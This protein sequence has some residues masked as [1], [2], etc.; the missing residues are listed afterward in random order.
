MRTSRLLHALLLA[1]GVACLACGAGAASRQQSPSS[2]AAARG[3]SAG[4]PPPNGERVFVRV[5]GASAEQIAVI[6]AAGGAIERL[7][8]DGVP[9]PDWSA[10]YTVAPRGGASTQTIVQA[11]DPASGAVLRQQAL[12]G[13]YALAATDLDGT[14]GGLSPSGRWLALTATSHGDYAARSS[15]LAVVDT[16]FMTPPKLVA[17]DGSFEFD[18]LSDD[19]ASL[20]LTERTR[21]DVNG[22]LDYRVRRFDLNAGALDPT[23]VVEKGGPEQMRG[24]RL[25]A[26]AAPNGDRLYSLYTN[27]P[28]GAFVHAL[29]LSGR[30]AVCIDLPNPPGR[31]AAAGSPAQEDL[32]LAWS[33][34]LSPGGSLLYAVNS[35]SGQVV[36]ID[37]NSNTVRRSVMLGAQPPR[38]RGPL[39]ALLQWLAPAPAAA[40]QLMHGGAALSADGGTLFV[41]TGNGV[42]AIDTGTLQPRGRIL[43]GQAIVGLRLSPDGARLYALPADGND[44]LVF[45]ASSGGLLARLQTG[46][47]PERIWQAR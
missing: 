35:A 34:A 4:Q 13:D 8:P 44:L 5:A 9:A 17:L 1:G 20:F 27:G 18:A 43:G 26:V 16:S 2:P 38:L 25:T 10:L 28:D 22:S 15:E 30:F 37:L 19:G 36:T 33:L 29:T 6:D 24:L 11:I 31:G 32:L 42:L 47:R 14:P 46:G 40:K 3:S 12:D 21:P 45:A 23:I 39:E 41:A 7:L